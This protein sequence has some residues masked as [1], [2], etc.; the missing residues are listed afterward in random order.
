MSTTIDPRLH[1]IVA[2]QPYPLVF[3]TVSGAHLYGFPS[4]DSDYD[5]R[6]VHVLPVEQVLGLEPLRETVEFL[7]EDP[8]SGLEFDIV[9]HDVAK[10]FRL[11]LKRNGYVLEQIFS[12]LVAFG[13]GFLTRLR[14]LAQKC[15][16]RH[17]H[18]HYRG[19]LH[20][21]RKLFEKESPKRAKTLLYA[22][23]VLLTGIHLLET[24]EVQAHLPTLNERFA[25]SFVP[26]LIAR[27][28]SA[29]FGVLTGVDAEFHREQIDAWEKRLTDAFNASTLPENAPT[30]ELNEFLVELRLNPS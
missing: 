7:G 29:E 4:P 8:A 16:T 15:V 22:Y 11:L 21:Q 10:Y 30:D 2:V 6:G 14:P 26:D 27:K 18:N 20:T 25:L 28:A 17:C 3:A 19:F 12:P 5:L 1:P 9:T 13:A 23:R 24:G